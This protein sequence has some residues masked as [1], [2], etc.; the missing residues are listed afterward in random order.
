ME[1]DSPYNQSSALAGDVD[2]VPGGPPNFQVS[3]QALGPLQAVGW[4]CCEG[5]RSQAITFSIFVS[6]VLFY[7]S[8]Q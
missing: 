3:D 4:L 1:V 6:S 7:F 2:R 8:H 5:N